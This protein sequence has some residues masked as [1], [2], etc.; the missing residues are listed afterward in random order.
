MKRKKP[1]HKTQTPWRL[2]VYNPLTQSIVTHFEPVGAVATSE[3]HGT[4]VAG[5]P[6]IVD[7]LGRTG[8]RWVSVTVEANK[9]WR[10]DSL[11]TAIAASPVQYTDDLL[12]AGGATRAWLIAASGTLHERQL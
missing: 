12:N 4:L 6:H 10:A 2:G 5:H 9:A 11:S 1:E 7:P 8:E 3:P